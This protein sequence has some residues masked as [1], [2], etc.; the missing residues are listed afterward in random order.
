M[1]AAGTKGRKGLVPRLTAVINTTD[2]QPTTVTQKCTFDF[3][4]DLHFLH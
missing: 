4:M 3:V 2:V 1:H